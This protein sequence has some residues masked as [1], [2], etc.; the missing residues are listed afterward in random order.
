MWRANAKFSKKTVMFRLDP[1]SALHPDHVTPPFVCVCVFMDRLRT[2]TRF[3]TSPFRLERFTSN[4]RSEG[5]VEFTKV[6]SPLFLSS[7]ASFHS[8][9]RKNPLL[10]IM[11]LLRNFALLALLAAFVS[12]QDTT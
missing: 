7:T 2:D 3:L 10:P 4:T 9:H 6:T 8:P 1:N 11:M 12:A 5:D